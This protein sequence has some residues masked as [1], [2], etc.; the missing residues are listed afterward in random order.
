MLNKKIA[1][2]LAI[3]IIL[4]I[5]ISV[6]GIF[7]WQGSK[8]SS[9]DKQLIVEN[10]KESATEF[11]KNKLAAKNCK[12]DF[13]GSVCFIEK[14]NNKCGDKEN[15]M[16][17][18]NFL[19][20]CIDTSDCSK[21]L[22]GSLCE[23]CLEGWMCEMTTPNPALVYCV[24]N[25]GVFEIKN[26]DKNQI[27]YCEFNDGSECEGE[28][29]FRKECEK[30]EPFVI[31]NKTENWQKYKNKKFGFEFEY[32]EG[33][34]ITEDKSGFA[35]HDA[36][37]ILSPKIENEY[38]AALNFVV[39]IEKSGENPKEWFANN[40]E[41]TD[42][43]EKY[44]GRTSQL[45][46]NGYATFYA[47]DILNSEKNYVFSNGKNLILSFSFK[48]KEKRSVY[49]YSYEDY[50]PEFEKLIKSVKFTEQ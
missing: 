45:T 16:I 24:E 3:G 50:L 6:G 11:L 46:V 28:A 39:D 12:K 25:G 10:S 22:G 44:K 9:T 49:S 5:A 23:K 15:L 36:L 48:E 40:W 32:P 38:N 1:S 19:C 29:Y 7:W 13:W 35:H 18:D 37:L 17:V 41:N 2:E 33:W 34:K 31:T 20:E 42:L 27:G 43:S 8:L 26:A 4:I 14:N 21:C 30:N 47:S